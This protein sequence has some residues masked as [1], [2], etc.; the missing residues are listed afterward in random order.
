MRRRASELAGRG[1]DTASGQVPED[2]PARL[3]AGTA[4][5]GEHV[6]AG[7]LGRAQVTAVL[8]DRTLLPESDARP[9]RS[10]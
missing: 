8:V 10:V 6:L 9:A 4:E 5:T 2:L 1:P 7:R 3:G